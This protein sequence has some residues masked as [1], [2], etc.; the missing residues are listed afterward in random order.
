ML[1]PPAMAGTVCELLSTKEGHHRSSAEAL[2]QELI[3]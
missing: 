2:Y 1:T 3:T